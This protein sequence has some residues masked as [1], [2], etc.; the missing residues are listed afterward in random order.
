MILPP[1][2]LDDRTRLRVAQIGDVASV[3]VALADALR[4]VADVRLFPLR[5]RG[6]R[7]TTA[8]KLLYG[9]LRAIDAANAARAARRWSADIAHVHWVPN[10]LAGVLFGSPWVLHAHGS[11]I[12]GLDR[13]RRLLFEPLVRSATAVVYATP[14]LAPVVRAIRPDATHL[15]VAIPRAT[16]APEREWDVIVASRAAYSKGSEVASAAVAA[17]LTNDER[18]RIG[19]VDGPDFDSAAVRL[20]FGPKDEF[21]RR[22]ARARV[23]IGQFRVPALGVSELEAMSVGRPVVTNVDLRLY[24]PPPPV[25]VAADAA[26]AAREVRR[27]LDDPAAG[28]ALGLAGKRWVEANHAPD[29]IAARAMQIYQDAIESVRRPKA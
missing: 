9:P 14:D 15:P 29:V 5:Q 12:R 2:T 18:L 24:D 17:L 6:A 8:T 10:G 25:L 20:A 26:A 3:A 22:L 27:L 23:V 7:R 21:V 13:V 16:V 11:D 19:A 4:D 28:D 1:S